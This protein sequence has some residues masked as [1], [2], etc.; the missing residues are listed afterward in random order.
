MAVIKL[1]MLVS[2]AFAAPYEDL[3]NF[4]VGISTGFLGD[5]GDLYYKC[6]PDTFQYEMQEDHQRIWKDY[7]ADKSIT[8]VIYDFYVFA[9]DLLKI[10]DTC[11][12]YV[13]PHALVSTILKDGPLLIMKFL[14]H[15]E[16]IAKDFYDAIETYSSDP[17]KAGT[18]LGDAMKQFLL[19]Y[20]P[21]L[22]GEEAPELAF[23]I[24]NFNVLEFSEGFITG[25]QSSASSASNCLK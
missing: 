9:D 7:D 13:Y 4:L 19:P 3:R 6:L 15:F 20:K 17:T 18:Y 25:L 10:Y 12:I 2:L 23:N 22:F 11:N 14:I 21:S 8:T 5:P 24:L 1:L 16:T